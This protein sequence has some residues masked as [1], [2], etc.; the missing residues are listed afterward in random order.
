M[1]AQWGRASWAPS[2]PGSGGMGEGV[3]RYSIPVKWDEYLLKCGKWLIAAGAAGKLGLSARADRWVLFVQMILVLRASI[4]NS[5][6]GPP[7]S[8]LHKLV[9]ALRQAIEATTV[10]TAANCCC[11]ALRLSLALFSPSFAPSYHL[12]L[13]PCLQTLSLLF[14]HLLPLPLLGLLLYAIRVSV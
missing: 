13:T 7:G 1:G 6:A 5:A 2:L 4:T 8:C 11:A 14:S 3:Y 9:L 10:M 12:Y